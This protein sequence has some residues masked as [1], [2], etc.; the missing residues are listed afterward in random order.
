[1]AGH[2]KWSQIKH[3]KAAVDAK[4]S[5]EFGRLAKTIAIESRAARGDTSS[6]SLKTAI[7]KAKAANMPKENIE[8]AVQK[9]IGGTGAALETITY[10][11]YGPGGVA[12]LID[13]LTD[14]R[15]RTVQELK[16]VVAKQGYQLAEPGAALWAFTKQDGEWVASSTL[17]IEDE[18][19]AT[20]LESL[21]EVLEA[22][23]DVEG[24][25]TNAE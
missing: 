17:L 20:Q 7:E 3:K 23:D 15:N 22:H 16:H 19:T 14:N 11:L 24:V 1:M 8:R 21:V 5:K 2:S 25:Y 9:G 4:R 18:T 13:T 10:E 6:P 12:I